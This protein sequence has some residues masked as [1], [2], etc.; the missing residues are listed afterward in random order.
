M[1]TMTANIHRV[2]AENP[3]G[4]TLIQLADHFKYSRT[5]V[6]HMLECLE[7]EGFVQLKCVRGTDYW[8]AR[9]GF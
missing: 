5:A 9:D 8:V 7:T 4:R 3:K 2:L 6:R 1:N